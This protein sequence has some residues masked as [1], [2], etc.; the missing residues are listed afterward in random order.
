MSML[1]R[2]VQEI[3]ERRAELELIER[4]QAE[5][6]ARMRCEWLPEQIS[7]MMPAALIVDVLSEA[8]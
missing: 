1:K 6:L 4:R 2:C 5:E 3:I 8:R 7:T